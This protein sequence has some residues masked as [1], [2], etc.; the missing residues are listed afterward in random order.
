M[1]KISLAHVNRFRVARLA[2]ADAAGKPLVVPVCFACGQRS[3]YS[4]VDEKPKRVPAARLRRLRNIEANPQ[5]SLLVDHYEE[6]WRRLSYILVEGSAE[7]L[8]AGKEHR[9]AIG[10]LRRKYAQYRK[11]QL[12]NKPV[13]KISPRRLISWKAG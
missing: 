2:T 10:L 4:V 11:M 6:N 8:P 9:A 5:V 13:F 1:T 12:D 3:I 7:V